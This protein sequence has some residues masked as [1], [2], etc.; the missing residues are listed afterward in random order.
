MFPVRCVISAASSGVAAEPL[1]TERARKT[2]KSRQG[3]IIVTMF[4]NVSVL[5]LGNGIR[6]FVSVL[7]CPQHFYK[8]FVL[9]IKNFS[10]CLDFTLNA[11]RTAEKADERLLIYIYI[12]SEGL[13]ARSISGT[14]RPCSALFNTSDI[15]F[16][17]LVFPP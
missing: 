10:L 6:Q 11:A 15:S 3:F 8:V 9:I 7:D 16:D 17:I 13:Q 1:T 4:S 5:F 2:Y 14:C 12:Y